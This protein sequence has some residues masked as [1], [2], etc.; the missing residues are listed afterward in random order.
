MIMKTPTT[1][2]RKVNKLVCKNVY[3][4]KTWER[5]KTA[6]VIIQIKQP[7]TIY[8]VAFSF[9]FREWIKIR[10]LK[11]TTARCK[12]ACQLKCEIPKDSLMKLKIKHKI[13]KIQKKAHIFQFPFL[14]FILKKIRKES[15]NGI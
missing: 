10:K 7:E 5:N 11:T 8:F 2:P 12:K 3:S 9:N 4:S 13:K 15:L 1:P 14:F 6:W